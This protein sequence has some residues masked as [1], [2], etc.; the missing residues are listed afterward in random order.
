M[1]HS[2]R[3]PSA[4]SVSDRTISGSKP[5]SRDS[6]GK[7]VWQDELDPRNFHRKVTRTA[8]F[9]VDTGR[10]VNEGPR[11]P[12]ALFRRGNLETLARPLLREHHRSAP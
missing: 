12:A 1:E 6:T 8:G 4:G 2:A 5:S 3:S 10:S 11:R 7:A 9:L